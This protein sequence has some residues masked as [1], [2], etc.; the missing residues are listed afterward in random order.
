MSSPVSISPHPNEEAPDPLSGA[1]RL[2]PLPGV[3]FYES[4]RTALPE[5]V[6]PFGM[7]TV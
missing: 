3:G 4:T 2:L 6:Q 5:G 1:P 7:S